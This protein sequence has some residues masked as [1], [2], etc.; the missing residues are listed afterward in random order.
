MKPSASITTFRKHVASLWSAAAVFVA[1]AVALAQTPATGV[2]GEYTSF[3]HKVITVAQQ[4][5]GAV[6]ILGFIRVGMM[7]A[8]EDK[9]EHAIPAAKRTMIGAVMI[10]TA[11]TLAQWIKSHFTAGRLG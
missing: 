1:P 8:D 4:I 10:A 9:S 6:I 2:A 11:A 5:G 7:F 3:L